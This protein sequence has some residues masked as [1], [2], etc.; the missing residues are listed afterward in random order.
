MS[1]IQTVGHV[2]T[3]TNEC[4]LPWYLALEYWLTMKQYSVH[5]RTIGNIIN[6]L[7]C[8]SNGICSIGRLHQSNQLF[9]IFTFAHPW[10]NIIVI[11]EIVGQ[12]QHKIN[13][14]CHYTSERHTTIHLETLIF[15]KKMEK[16]S[17]YISCIYFKATL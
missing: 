4:V 3:S 15:K 8:T 11:Y 10:I 1:C 2:T 9:V 17:M 16:L 6:D 12:I 7:T 13:I 5:K 14:F